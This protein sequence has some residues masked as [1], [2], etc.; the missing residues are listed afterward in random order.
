MSWLK[1]RVNALESLQK[2]EKKKLNAVEKGDEKLIYSIL[3]VSIDVMV[4]I[5]SKLSLKELFTA[6]HTSKVFAR[7]SSHTRLWKLLIQKFYPE[8]DLSSLD[9]F[10]A[11]HPEV[12]YRN[13]FFAYAVSSQVFKTS[14]YTNLYTMFNQYGDQ[15]LFVFNA[16]EGLKSFDIRIFPSYDNTDERS[17]FYVINVVTTKIF[18]SFGLYMRMSPEIKGASY[19]LLYHRRET[20]ESV[21]FKL[22]KFIALLM[23]IGYKTDVNPES[24]Q[25]TKSFTLRCNMCGSTPKVKCCKTGLYCSKECQIKDWTMHKNTHF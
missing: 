13:V 24:G 6:F 1:C 8:F 11:A 10:M 18:A 15:V 17:P 3:H 16:E 4:I 12:S 20:K 5:L 19:D 23:S 2:R 25:K 22:L 21:K 7:L 14:Q 9:E